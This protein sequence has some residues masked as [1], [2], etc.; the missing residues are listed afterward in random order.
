[1][2]EEHT[3]A[4]TAP[5]PEKVPTT[6]SRSPSRLFWISLSVVLACGT[7][8]IILAATL[9]LTRP[10]PK[11]LLQVVRFHFQNHQP[12]SQ[13]NQSALLNKPKNTVT[14]YVTSPNNQTSLVL[15]DRKNGYICY[16]PSGR[17]SCYLR[18]MD[19][20][21]HEAVQ[22]AFNLSDHRVDP[23]PPPNHQTQYYREFLA[24]VP[25]R[26]VRPE[27]A[28]EAVGTLC[29]QVPIYWVKKKE[30]PPKQRLIYLCIDIC[31]PSNI[32]ISI[33]FYYLP[34]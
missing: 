34:E 24:I 1:M 27:E 11:P 14:Y 19:A 20:W 31:F 12:G 5:S 30:G 32:C 16:K 4:P 9:S 29:Q 2:M 21:D 3:G 33:C 18:M 6:E 22:M 25:G 28:S 7:V 15:F 23:L 8:C 13:M 10:V 26:Q 17:N